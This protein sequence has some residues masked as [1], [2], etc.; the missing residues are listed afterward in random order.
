[1]TWFVVN[2][3]AAVQGRS[4]AMTATSSR[5]GTP[6]FTPAAATAPVKPRANVTPLLTPRSWPKREGLETHRLGIA[7]HGVEVLQRRARGAL[8]EVVEHREGD[9]TRRRLVDDRVHE[10]PVAAERRLRRGERARHAY[11]RLL[12]VVARVRIGHV[13]CA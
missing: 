8:H 6:C 1:M 2:R 7:P 12:R 10:A 11:E 5:S 3:P 9:Q 13:A 4:G